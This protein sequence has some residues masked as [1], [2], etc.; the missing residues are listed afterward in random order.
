M[1]RRFSNRTKFTSEQLQKIREES[2]SVGSVVAEID[3]ELQ[4]RETEDNI[5]SMKSD[6]QKLTKP[7]W[8]LVP[9]FW[10]ALAALFVAL[11]QY[12]RPMQSAAP[13]NQYTIS[14]SPVTT[15]TSHS[16]SVQTGTT[17]TSQ[18]KHVPKKP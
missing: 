5:T 16:Q 2:K 11:L 15:M 3:T 6:I 13:N 12:F 1:T 4:L 8:S 9:I 7:H 14:S 18:P 17:K 10:I